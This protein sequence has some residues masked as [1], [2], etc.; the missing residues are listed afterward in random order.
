MVT[1]EGTDGK[2]P[3]FEKFVS[4]SEPDISSVLNGGGS[5]DKT[6]ETLI[7]SIGAK[8]KVDPVTFSAYLSLMVNMIGGDKD[9]DVYKLVLYSRDEGGYKP[10]GGLI[11]M[12]PDTYVKALKSLKV[13]DPIIKDTEKSA[14]TLEK[15]EKNYLIFLRARDESTMSY[16]DIKPVGARDLGDGSS[17]KGS[18]ERALSS[19]RMLSD[20]LGVDAVKLAKYTPSGDSGDRYSEESIVVAREGSEIRVY[21]GSDSNIRA[22]AYF[23]LY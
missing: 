7:K 17:Y 21:A 9:T 8:G 20:V 14:E 3:Y 4:V 11:Q 16:A 6:L 5:V 13:G 23:T 15:G 1:L 2:N 19:L 22:S 18:F 10:V 12:S